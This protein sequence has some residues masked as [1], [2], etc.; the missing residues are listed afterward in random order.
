MTERLFLALWP[1][2]SVRAALDSVSRGLRLKGGR[3]IPARNLHVTLVF[4]GNIDAARRVCMEQAVSS[5]RASAFEFLLTAV[6]W[7]RKTGIV[8][9]TPAEISAALL[10]LVTSLQ[11]ALSVCQQSLERRPYRLHVTL[12]RDVQAGPRLQAIAP[13]TWRAAEV[14]LVSSGLTPAGSEYTVARRWPLS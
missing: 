10:D 5:V 8:W 4:L 7:R 1:D 14:C 2:S 13:I 12:A 6:E 3:I 9:A 11:S